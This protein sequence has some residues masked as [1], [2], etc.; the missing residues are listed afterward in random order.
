[1]KLFP[2]LTALLNL[3][4]LSGCATDPVSMGRDTYIV[5]DTGAWSWSSGGSLKAG[6]FQKA[7]AFCAAKGREMQPVG[8]HQNDADFSTFG[9]AEVQF[10][11]VTPD[12]PEYR[13]PTLRPSMNVIVQEPR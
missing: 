12:D 2:T 5:T 7:N 1:M 10:R 3:F 13:R 9:H 4:A 6:L 8:T 11:C